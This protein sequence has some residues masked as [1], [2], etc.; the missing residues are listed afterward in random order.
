MPQVVLTYSTDEGSREIA[1][2]EGKVSFGRGSEAD[3]RLDDDGLSRL[4]ATVHREG[5]NVWI[6]D[7]HSTNGSFVNGEKV[8][9][10]GTVLSNGD[11]IKIGNQT[12]LTIKIFSKQASQPTNSNEKAK[13]VAA[14]GADLKGFPM[15]IPLAIGNLV[16]TGIVKVLMVMW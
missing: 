1:L 5:D 6:L 12:T 7:E 9:S 14:S 13:T 3:Y 16:V 8:S 15:L 2:E 11:K 4:H 10:N